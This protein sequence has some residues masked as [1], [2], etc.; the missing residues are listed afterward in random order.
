[1]LNSI[2]IQGNLTKDPE[3][4][5]TT[6]G[7]SVL[8]FTIAC[9]RDKKESES[10]FFTVVAWEGTAEFIS[11]YFRKGSQI[12]VDGHLQSRNYEDRD[13]KKRTATEIVADRVYFAGRKETRQSAEP[14]PFEEYESDE[15]L[16]F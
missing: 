1:M 9:D 5:R 11:K 4:S 10:F 14:A 7:K 13:G 15:D 8:S 6:S 2:N 16:P 12:I 3:L